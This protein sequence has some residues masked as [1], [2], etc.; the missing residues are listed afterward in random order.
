MFI[1]PDYYPTSSRFQ[2]RGLRHLRAGRNALA[3]VFSLGKIGCSGVCECPSSSGC[4]SNPIIVCV[5]NTCNGGQPATGVV[6][7][8]LSGSTVV[9]TCTTDSSG[10]CTFSDLPPGTYT[11][12]TTNTNPRYQ[13][14]TSSQTLGCGTR[15]TITLSPASGYFCSPCFNEPIPTTLIATVDGTPFSFT[16][17]LPSSFY[18]SNTFANTI[19]PTFGTLCPPDPTAD[20][21]TTGGTAYGLISLDLLSGCTVTEYWCQ[22]T[23]CTQNASVECPAIPYDYIVGEG[24]FSEGS[25]PNV[26]A[27]TPV[28][29]F[30]TA[31]M[32]EGTCEGYCLAGAGAVASLGTGNPVPVS[33]TLTFTSNVGSPSPPF[34]TMTLTE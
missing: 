16:A 5:I 2:A 28:S 14:S 17:N 21:C 20:P 26:C 6:V 3:G 4:G 8:I 25:G 13:T 27:D 12:N 32:N 15:Y 30:P 33:L 18:P 23:N 10:C 22:S 31:Q 11:V 9:A 19:N 34:P 24:F 1:L 29:N 7:Q